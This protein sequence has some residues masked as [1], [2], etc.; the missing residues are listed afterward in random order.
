MRRC[1][2]LTAF[3][4]IAAPAAAQAPIYPPPTEVKAAFLKLLDRPKVPLDVQTGAV[5]T[6]NDGAVLERLSF[7]TEKKTD[8]SLERVS[9]IVLRPAD[10]TGP[11]AA[12]IV[13]H[14]TGGSK[15]GML[16]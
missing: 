14:G 7:A 12:V 10:R 11:F 16:A 2:S 3:L 9:A 15:D 4:I 8:G 13:L 6:V 1:A 5:T